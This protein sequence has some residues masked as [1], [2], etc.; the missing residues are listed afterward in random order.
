[1]ILAITGSRKYNDYQELMQVIKSLA[2]DATT[3]IS[4]G[5]KG[6]DTLAAKYAN[7]HKLTL[8]EIKPDYKK[9][10]AR[11]APLM[12]NTTI[13]AKADKVIAFYYKTQS[14]GT[15]DTAKKAKR[16]GKLLAE[17]IEGKVIKSDKDLLLF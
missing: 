10:L 5:A 16:A 7:E 2:P 13:V 1:M 11:V 17:V 12:R 14:G 8:V 6:A 9:Y 4:G 3:I 15:L